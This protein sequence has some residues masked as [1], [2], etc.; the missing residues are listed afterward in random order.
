MQDAFKSK[1][2]G[3]RPNGWKSSNSPNNRCAQSK[4]GEWKGIFADRGKTRH[5]K[6][7]NTCRKGEKGG[8]IIDVSAKATA[9]K[10][11]RSPHK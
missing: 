1:R 6:N 4:K 10:G 3:V 8:L 5:V 11:A 9:V 7:A 2:R